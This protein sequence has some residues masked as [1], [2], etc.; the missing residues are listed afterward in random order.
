[1]SYDLR[2]R[3]RFRWAVTGLTGAV[4]A[5][6]VTATGAFAGLAHQQQAE[7]DAAAQAERDA[8]LQA[9]E[10]EQ[11]RYEKRVRWAERTAA[12][13]AARAAA[14]QKPEIIWRERPTRTRVTTQYVTGAASP[15][16]TSVSPGSP[17]P[18]GGHSGSTGSTG[19]TGG[20]STGSTGG[21]SGGSSGGSGGS[22]GGSS[23]TPTPP[24]PHPPPPP[25]PPTS[26][27]S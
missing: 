11:A 19:S 26:S 1:M 23:P 2:S 22:S 10:L 12:R 17:A 9:Y 6:A 20:T 25:P 15:G 21:S 18:S 13:A 24:P 27:G 16:S 5:G 4:A 3:E 8:E 14:A 7:K